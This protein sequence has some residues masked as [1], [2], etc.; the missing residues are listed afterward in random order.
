[1]QLHAI[2]KLWDL[3]ADADYVEEQAHSDTCSDEAGHL[4]LC[5]SE[6][7]TTGVESSRSMRLLGNI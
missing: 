3:F 5:L 6:A 1:V 2:Q 7:T 4:C